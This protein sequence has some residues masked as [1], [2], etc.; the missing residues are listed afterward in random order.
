MRVQ[1]DD[2]AQLVNGYFVEKEKRPQVDSL[3]ASVVV[4][5]K[6]L[7]SASK[8]ELPMSVVRY[9]PKCDHGV[10]GQRR[11]DRRCKHVRLHFACP[12]SRSQH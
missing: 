1:F 10:K 4:A 9:K 12:K 11:V 8:A 5:R 7:V 2:F 6:K 3:V